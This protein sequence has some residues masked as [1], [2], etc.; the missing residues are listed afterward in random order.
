VGFQWTFK[1]EPRVFDGYHA[2]STGVIFPS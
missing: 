2:G 1:H